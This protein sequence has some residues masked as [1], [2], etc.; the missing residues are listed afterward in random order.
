MIKL[1]IN[2]I[3]VK[4][5]EGEFIIDVAKKNGIEIPRFCY[6][7]KLERIGACRLC[8]VEIKNGSKLEASCCTQ[9]K[10]GMEI[11]THS[12]RVLRARRMNVL[13]LLANHPN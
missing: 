9:V 8:V 12:P 4:S 5:K 2:G 11:S 3:E 6:N 1:K 13:L 7:K 10:E